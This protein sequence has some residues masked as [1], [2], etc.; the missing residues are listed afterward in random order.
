[1][2]NANV[3]CCLRDACGGPDW[4]PTRAIDA[5][6]AEEFEFHQELRVRE[7]VEAGASETTARQRAA[8][9]FGD[10][11]KLRRSCRRITQGS[12]IVIPM[13][14]LLGGMLVVIL[15][16]VMNDEERPRWSRL[17]PFSGIRW[18][19][20]LPQIEHEGRWYGLLR[21]EG[22]AVEEILA[23]CAATYPGQEQKRFSEDLV[24]V[25]TGLGR[26]DSATM[27]LTVRDHESGHQIELEDVALSAEKRAK[28]KGAAFAA[29]GQERN[30]AAAEIET[31]SRVAPYSA[32][33]WRE[34]QPEVQVDGIWY[35]LDA[36]GGAPF[37]AICE[38]LS[39]QHAGKEAKR[40]SEDIADVLREMGVPVG[41]QIDLDVIDPTT[42][43]SIRLADVPLTREKRSA[44]REYHRSQGIPDD[45]AGAVA[46]GGKPRGEASAAGARETPWRA[47]TRRFVEE[48]RLV[49]AAA[50][51]AWQLCDR[52]ERQRERYER[53]HSADRAKVERKLADGEGDTAGLQA[54]LRE[55]DA[56]V[57]AIFSRTL[58]PGLER[59][60]PAEKA[61]D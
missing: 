54:R 18:E 37:E 9:E 55:L 22:V 3:L 44:A 14:V 5:E 8:A 28:V 50:S 4:R 36:I 32:L 49:D 33:R 45:L 59:L 6:I 29:A 34:E 43:R 48:H 27:S 58:K 57:E 1:M 51:K 21:V 19:S 42:H 52:C 12:R 10:V 20:G 16:G 23:H 26:S 30:G 24:E 56:P 60:I 39:A 15:S 13:A 2:K 53:R 25:M 46:Q 41:E 38:H 17:A 7:L 47:Y 35:L 11:H 61:P 31:W 40:F